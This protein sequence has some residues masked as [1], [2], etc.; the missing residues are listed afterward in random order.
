MV[1][2]N[3]P[4]EISPKDP[5]NKRF[6]NDLGTYNETEDRRGVSENEKLLIVTSYPR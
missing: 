3:S 5:G 4:F 1:G 2:I 6:K